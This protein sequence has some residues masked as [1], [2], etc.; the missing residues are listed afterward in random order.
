[1]VPCSNSES[2]AR[3]S[4]TRKRVTILERQWECPVVW[5]DFE[6]LCLPQLVFHAEALAMLGNILDAISSAKH[7]LLGHGHITGINCHG[8]VNV[9]AWRGD[10]LFV[11]VFGGVVFRGKLANLCLVS[12]S[13]LVLSV[14]QIDGQSVLFPL[15]IACRC[16]PL[17]LGVVEI[18]LVSL[19]VVYVLRAS[20]A[21]QFGPQHGFGE[22]KLHLG[23]AKVLQNALVRRDFVTILLEG[24]CGHHLGTAHHYRW[25]H[26][27]KFL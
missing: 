27:A 10:R 8:A 18:L 2:T 23:R 21:G 3:V 1:M 16:T 25:P 13:P 12:K 4:L 26:G 22:E 9:L 11:V 14:R 24:F 5:V 7:L 20:E 17:Q 15:N 19:D 6:D